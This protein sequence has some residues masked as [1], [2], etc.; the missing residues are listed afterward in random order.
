MEAAGAKALRQGAG[1]EVRR[2]DCAGPGGLWEG[3]RLLLQVTWELWKVL[4]RV[5]M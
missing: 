4:S 3:L 5:G 2:V 1:R